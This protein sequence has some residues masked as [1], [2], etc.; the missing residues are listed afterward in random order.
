MDAHVT[1]L[2]QEVQQGQQRVA[3]RGHHQV[4]VVDH[5]IHLGPGPPAPLAELP[6][7]QV[8]PWQPPGQHLVQLGQHLGGGRGRPRVA[9]QVVGVDGVQQGTAVVDH[10]QLGPGRRLPGREA[11]DEGPQQGGLARLAV[12]EDDQVGVGAAQVEVDR[13]QVGLGHADRHARLAVLAGGREL[14]VVEAGRQHVDRPHRGAVPGGLDPADQVLEGLLEPGGGGLAVDAGQGGLE[15]EPV[16]GQAAPGGAQGDVGGLLAVDL[17][18]Q[19]VGQPQL[20]PVADGVAQVGP[21]VQPAVGRHQ[22]VDAVAEPAGG[23]VDHHRLQVLELLADGRPVVQDQ[24]DV[25]EV[26]AAE[27]APVAQ[28]PEGVDGVD[29]L[30]QEQLLAVVQQGLYGADDPADPLGVVP[31]GHAADVRGAGH[32]LEGAAAEVDAVELGLLGPV[33]EQERR[34]QG[35]QQRALARLGAAH[36]GQVPAGAGEVGHQGLLGLVLGPVQDAEGHPQA[37]PG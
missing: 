24:E 34:Q 15:V 23:Q 17:G 18:V 11:A 13:G 36:H 2:G 6:D 1:A 22:Q 20:D 9:G 8:G 35:A 19:R 3:A 14:G 37:A 25:A 21:D 31:A 16:Q 27:L 32:G 5:H 30:G 29:A 26:V 28:G 12:A 4:V 33:G 10:Q 7:G